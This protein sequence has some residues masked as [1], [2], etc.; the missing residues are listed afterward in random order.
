MYLKS[1][2]FE[3]VGPITNFRIDLPIQN[4]IPK[5]L[6]LVGPNGSGK[7]T[8]LSFVVNA[9]VGFKQQVFDEAEIEQKRV[10]RVRSSHFIR[11]GSNWYHARLEFENGLSLEEWVLDRPKGRFESEVN[12][13]PTETGWQQISEEE[14]NRY[15]L[16]PNRDGQI[17]TPDRKSVV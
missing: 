13:L 8:V 11:G 9:L 7:S 16:E 10:Y 6:V 4:G 2:A 17:P 12:P 5:P 3:N 15:L 14:T 1:F